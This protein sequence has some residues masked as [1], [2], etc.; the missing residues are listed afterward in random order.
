MNNRITIFLSHSHKDEE[1]VR[2]IRDVLEILDCEPLIFFLKCLDDENEELEEF[3]KREIRARNVFLYCKSENSENSPWVKKEL[4]YIR[5]IDSSRLYEL[6]IEKDFSRSLISFL[7]TLT[8]ILKRNRVFLTYSHYDSVVANRITA[9]LQANEYNV[10]RLEDISASSNWEAEIK[11]NITEAVTEGLYIFLA[12][13][14]CLQS[15]GCLEELRIAYNL[16]TNEKKLIVPIMLGS[17]FQI[18]SSIIPNEINEFC[19]YFLPATPSDSELDE[20][21]RQLNKVSR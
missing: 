8:A 15:P 3:I 7:Q 5:S 1:K 11:K 18:N 2:K 19:W 12:S 13:E 4:E 20:L 16:Q 6:D 10:F 21:I 14:R 17:E 9:H